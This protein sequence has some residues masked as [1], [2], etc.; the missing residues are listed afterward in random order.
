MKLTVKEAAQLLG[1]ETDTLYKHIS[2][3]TGYA[4]CFTKENDQ[5]KAS[6]ASLMARQIELGDISRGK[7]DRMESIKIYLTGED[8]ALLEQKRSDKSISAFCRWLVMRGLDV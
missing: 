5:W 1:L 8:R 2:R 7:N 3:G 6:R 4:P